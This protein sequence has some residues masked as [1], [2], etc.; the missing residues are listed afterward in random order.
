MRKLTAII[1]NNLVNEIIVGN[2]TFT[3]TIT[4]SGD[5]IKDVTDIECGK[6]WEYDPDN[7]TFHNPEH[8]A[9]SKSYNYSGMSLEAYTEKE[10]RWRDLELISTDNLVAVTDHTHYD[11]W[12]QFR[13]DLRDYPQKE[14]FPNLSLR[15]VPS[16]FTSDQAL[17][18]NPSD[19]LSLPEI[20]EPTPTPAPTIYAAYNSANE[21]VYEST[22][23][24]DYDTNDFE[25]M[26][27]ISSSYFTDVTPNTFE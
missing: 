18:E 3:S 2:T 1:K 14:G 26:P 4:S 6:R 23:S 9:I 27:A 21:L 8:L 22:N 10:L 15:P 13:Q 19:A 25:S 20:S 7:D 16:H 17:L 11:E 5:I 12:M 24:I